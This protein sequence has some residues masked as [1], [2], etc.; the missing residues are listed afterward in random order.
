VL[1]FVVAPILFDQFGIQATTWLL[2]PSIFTFIRPLLVINEEPTNVPMPAGA[3]EEYAKTKNVSLWQG[4]RMTLTNK[5]F[6]I[7][8]HSL[9]TFLFGLQFFS[10][11]SHLWPMI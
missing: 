3:V 7:S 5:I 8:L 11:A 1:A 10:T 9:A 4:V 2:L 6:R